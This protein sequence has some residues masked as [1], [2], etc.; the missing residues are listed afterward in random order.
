MFCHLH[1]CHR[2][3]TMVGWGGVATRRT[4]DGS[5]RYWNEGGFH[6]IQD[7]MGKIDEKIT[8]AVAD[9]WKAILGWDAGTKLSGKMPGVLLEDFD[10]YHL[11]GQRLTANAL[12]L[13]GKHVCSSS[14]KKF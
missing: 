5:P 3:I 1:R 11:A 12:V 10:T 2:S 9:A 8:Q 6:C 4:Q 14:D 13:T 7:G